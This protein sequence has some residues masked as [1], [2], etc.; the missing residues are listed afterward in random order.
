MYDADDLKHTALRDYEPRVTG[1]T[2]ELMVQLEKMEGTPVNVSDWFN[3]YSF[4]VMG[5]LAWAKSFGMVKGGIKHYFMNALHA[6]MKS[7]GFFSHMLW[8]F[9]IFTATPIL[10]ADFHRFWNWVIA[11]VNA[12]REVLFPF[13]L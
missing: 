6:N 2:D 7:F 11:Q 8:L 9:P 13:P 3:F 5:D 10:N 4:D 12:R 1:Y